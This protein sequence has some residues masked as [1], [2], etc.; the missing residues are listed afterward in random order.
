M[1]FFRKSLIWLKCLKTVN[2]FAFSTKIAQKASS[3]EIKQHENLPKLI[4]KPDS[5]LIKN[6]WCEPRKH[7]FFVL[8]MYL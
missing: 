4:R 6:W 8:L 1:L 2:R 7:I 3:V 5:I